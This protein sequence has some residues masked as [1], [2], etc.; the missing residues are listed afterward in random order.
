MELVYVVQNPKSA[1]DTLLVTSIGHIP[2]FSLE[3]SIVTTLLVLVLFAISSASLI[4][5]N[6]ALMHTR[7]VSALNSSSAINPLIVIITTN[8]SHSRESLDLLAKTYINKVIY[9]S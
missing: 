1:V 5:L 3:P 8:T 9:S 4:L 7:L 2:T 6:K